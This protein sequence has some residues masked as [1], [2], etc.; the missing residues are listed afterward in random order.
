MA[1]RPRA[2]QSKRPIES[3]DHRDKERLN[4][5]PVGLVTP[6]TDEDAGRKTYAYD[7]HLD[8]QLQWAGKAEHT[9][10]EVPTVSLHVHERIDPR[11]IIEATRK[12]N[13]AAPEQGSLFELPEQN[14]PV[15]EAIEFYRHRHNWTNRLVAGDSLLVM[16]SL[17]EKEGMAGKVQMVYIDPPYGIR[18]GSNFQP[19]V[20][21]R[22]VRDGRDE[23]LT[24]EPETIR[25]YRD[26]WELG[27]HSYL[28]YLRDRLLLSREMLTESGSCFVQISDEN[29]HLIR[30]LMDEVFGVDNFIALIPYR[31]KT[32]PFGTNFAEQMADFIVWY[33]RNKYDRQGR[34]L[35]KYRKLFREMRYGPNSGYHWCRMEDGSDRRL[36]DV[37]EEFGQIPKGARIFTSKSLEPSGPMQAGM[38]NY[39]YRGVEYNH[40]R[41]G[42]GTTREAMD[43][44]ALAGRLLPAGRLVRYALFADDK[45]W[46]DLTVPWEDTSGADGK[47]YAVQTNTKVIARCMLMTT[48]PGDLVF[49]PTC[50]SGTTAYV[51]E[52]WGRRWI[53]CD[54]SRVSV[55]LAKQRLMTATF[56]YYE[57]AHPSEGVGSGFNY[58]TVPHITLGSIANNPYIV[59]GMSQV[60]IDNAI[61][62]HAPQETLY[63]QPVVDGGRRRVTGPFSVEAV[64]APAVKPIDAVDDAGRLPGDDTV[65]RSGETL[66]QSDWRDELLKTGIRGK[67]GQ[68]IRFARFEPLPGYRHLHADGETLPNMDGADSFKEG[69][70]QTAQ[71]VVVSFGPDHAPLE[72]RQVNLALQE[73]ETLRPSPKIIV[74]AA[75]QFDPEAAKDID[76]TN[77]SGVTLLKAQMNPDLLTEDLKK[78]RASN[79]SFWLIGQ[80]DVLLH[81]IRRGQNTGKWQVRV[82]GFDYY[83]TKSGD[84]ESGGEDKIAMWMLDTDYDGRSLY[85]RQVFFPMA[86]SR[87]GWARL[88]RN[89]KAEIDEDLIEAYRGTV[90]LPFE[91][92][93]HQRIAVKI[94]DDRGIE[95]L[96]VT[97]LS[98]TAASPIT[99][100]ERSLEAQSGILEN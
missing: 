97:G 47:V 10:F 43:R 44:L 27:I 1:R 2:K 8:P 26:T 49:D 62:L 78:K 99:I 38:F 57:V 32:M 19:F 13:G 25:A 39:T 87:D 77:W 11:T 48:D 3:Y 18:Y 36:T 15:R 22:D 98:S 80:P 95:S 67:S 93:E 100:E 4:N 66:R 81:Q 30:G 31:T 71:R 23:D 94:V 85:P 61:A 35:A 65:A 52:Q 58:K 28:S 24:Q 82:E 72:Q 12:R 90:S 6:A 45:S 63:D 34:P 88:A 41:N 59:G 74:F 75:F 84:V 92:G 69:A 50:G 83:N 33:A 51:A 64:P 68:F 9:S 53:T 76:E 16:N 73:A 14:P 79:E 89:L 70:A 7:P 37:M 86:G 40:P 21:R 20:N 17:L 60:E 55:A 42:Y 96:R 54:T 5:P 29:V 91:A 56:D 46:A